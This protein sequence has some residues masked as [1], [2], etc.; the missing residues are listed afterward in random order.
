MVNF[1]FKLILFLAVI[2][3]I[4]AFVGDRLGH[5]IGRRRMSIF[6]LRPRQTGILFTVL[7]GVLIAL[8]TLGFLLASSRSARL[9]LFGLEKLENEIIVKTSELKTISAEQLEAQKQL[10]TLKTEQEKSQTEISSLQNLKT[11]LEKQISSIK[12][13]KIIFSA[14]ETIYTE[15]INGG[16][17]AQ[18]AA[19]Y[20]QWALDRGNQ[21]LSQMG[22]PANSLDIAPDEWKTAGSFIQGHSGKIL[23]QINSAANTVAGEKITAHFRPLENR[24]I[25]LKGAVLAKEFY[26]RGSTSVAV[27]DRIRQLLSQV[28]AKAKSDGV[29]PQE[30]GNVGNLPY[31]KIMDTAKKVVLSDTGIDLQI[32]ATNDIR[33]SGPLNV[34]LRVFYR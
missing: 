12:K 16:V 8:F 17:D 26:D 2:S 30:N 3:G 18:A 29:L 34:D 4:I 21:K 28:S 15:E 10:G 33:V 22:F 27:E 5:W 9:A 11:Q 7:T 20:L 14:N 31:S 19:N 23:L 24:I 1:G 13:G 25:Y 6:N 32:V